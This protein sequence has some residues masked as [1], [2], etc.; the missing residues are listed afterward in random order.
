M[1]FVRQSSFTIGS[2]YFLYHKHSKP[3]CD[4]G[5]TCTVSNIHEVDV[6][7]LHLVLQIIKDDEKQP[8]SMPN[9]GISRTTA[10]NS[11]R[12]GS[13]KWKLAGTLHTMNKDVFI[14]PRNNH[15]L[16]SPIIKRICKRC[17][18]ILPLLS[19]S[20]AWSWISPTCA[21]STV[22]MCEWNVRPNANDLKTRRAWVEHWGSYR[23][24][25]SL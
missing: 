1:L 15:T 16:E 4:F 11:Y 21:Y 3:P 5:N 12:M 9:D 8:P 18:D 14:V 25:W 13:Y 20:T 19:K 17:E 24:S 22:Q 23:I 10:S 7:C 6:R 2:K